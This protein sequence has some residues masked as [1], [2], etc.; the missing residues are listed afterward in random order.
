MA[1]YTIA[2]TKAAVVTAAPIAAI[3]PGAN[4]RATIKEIGVFQ[5]TAV[6]S[7]IGLIRTLTLGTATTSNT[8]QPAHPGDPA[9]AAALTTAWSTAPTISGTPNYLRRIIL[10]ATI[11][12]GVI[13]SFGYGD[14]IAL[15]AATSGLVLWN[16]GGATSAALELYVTLEE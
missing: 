1:T 15:N 14:M 11:G 2:Q 7:S 12:A 6:A 16:F 9:G 3:I 13:W 10:P 4:D 8:V 5:S